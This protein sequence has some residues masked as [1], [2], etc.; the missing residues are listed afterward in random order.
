MEGSINQDLQAS[1]NKRQTM[2]RCIP[3]HGLITCG[4]F[5]LD[6]RYQCQPIEATII[7]GLCSSG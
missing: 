5:A 2:S 1:K 3:R 4:T 7:Q 6:E